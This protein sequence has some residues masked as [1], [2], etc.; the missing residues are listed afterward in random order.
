[1]SQGPNSLTPGE[2]EGK[3]GKEPVGKPLAQAPS[4]QYGRQI[5][6]GKGRQKH[7]PESR[8]S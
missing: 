2:Q 3:L 7:E 8:T 5:L 1:M 4:A 6:R